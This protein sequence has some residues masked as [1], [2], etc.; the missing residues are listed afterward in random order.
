[1]NAFRRNLG[2][3]ID[4]ILLTPDLMRKTT[5]YQIDKNARATER[6]SDHAPVWVEIK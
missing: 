5:Q 4:H 3:R 2:M 1:M 6:P